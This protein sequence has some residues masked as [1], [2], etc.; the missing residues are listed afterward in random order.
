[1]GEAE[2]VDWLGSFTR[3]VVAALRRGAE[4]GEARGDLLRVGY[5]R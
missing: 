5:P 1:M 3:E 4:I 2:R